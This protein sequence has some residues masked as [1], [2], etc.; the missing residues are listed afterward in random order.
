VAEDEWCALFETAAELLGLRWSDIDTD[1]SGASIR[2]VLVAVAG[3]HSCLSCGEKHRG[4]FLKPTTKSIAGARW[5]PLVPPA[6]EAL[7]THR[8]RQAEQRALFG[9]DYNDHGLVFAQVDGRPLRPQAATDRFHALTD[10]VPAVNEGRPLPRIRLHDLRHGAASILLAGGVP[11]EIVSMILGH[12]SPA[13][14]RQIYI[15]V[16]K[17]PTRELAE[18]AADLLTRHRPSQTSRAPGTPDDTTQSRPAS[19]DPGEAVSNP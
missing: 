3:E 8:Q 2:Q 15:H 1:L 9:P 16:L 4:C 18:L 13:V 7:T 14:T 12:A 19:T 6:R 10:A 5:V 17:G 11:L